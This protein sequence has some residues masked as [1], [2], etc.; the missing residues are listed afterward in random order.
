MHIKMFTH[1]FNSI[2]DNIRNI[3]LNI[4]I[5][6]ISVLRDSYDYFFSLIHLHKYFINNKKSMKYL[7][8]L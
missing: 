3:F 7:S 6:R 1:A 4:N 2:T 5:I 8:K